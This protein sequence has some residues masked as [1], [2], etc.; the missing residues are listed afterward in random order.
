VQAS[1][2]R[3]VPGVGR[4]A[5]GLRRVA[6]PARRPPLPLVAAGALVA[7]LALVP[8]AYLV[9]RAAGVADG[10]LDLVFRART[11]QV[12]ANTLVLA[13]LVGAGAVALGLPI[14]LLTAR[15][16][17]PFRRAVTILAVVP[18]AVPSY[19]LAFAVIGMLG[20]NGT[21][22]GLLAPLGVERLPS[23]YGLPGATLVL[24]LA[25]YPLVVLGVR[26]GA[27]RFDAGLLEAARTLGDNERSAFRHV[28]L[29]ILLPAI[30]GGALLAIL[31]ALAD[32]GSVSL[33]QFDSLSRAIYVQYRATFDRS[34][35]A[36]L[37]LVLA[38]LALSVAVLEAWV[39]SRQPPA[40]ARSR[41]R[42][43]PPFLLGRWRWPAFAFCA[44]VIGLALVLPVGTLVAWLVRGLANDEPLRLVP[45]AA[46]NTLVASGAAAG[47]AILLAAP[48]A[49]L[50]VRSPGR[51]ASAVEGAAL[52]S[53]ALPGIVVALAVVFLA[54]GAIPFAYQTFGLLALAYAVRFLP[55]GL[56]PLRDGLRSVSPSLEQ[57]ARVLGRRPL[58]AFWSVTL[59]LLRPGLAAGLALVFLTTAK[60]LPMTLILAPT[61]FA[62][63]ATQVWGAVGDGFYARA[64]PSALLLVG[65]SL[66]SVALLL[67][68][69]G[70]S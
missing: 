20:P 8:L 62:T 1:L 55:Q 12:V 42:P 51:V 26:A 37:S 15:T 54:T 58:G 9:I 23:I 32:F 69:E 35:A 39:R 17:L 34:L 49:L 38:A 6:P 10:S 67:R 65:L 18:L 56:N 63:L 31:Y 68:T 14:G 46:W 11:A 29:P 40:V 61:G 45:G 50:L 66:A 7:L 33:L 4:V 24:T 44:A 41:Q 16:D 36:V 13:L 52:T 5:G 47:V 22:A 43:L 53:Y 64:A 70:R 27:R 21:L 28:A 2:P 57:S 60:E 3:Q 19:V 25:T 48:V 59:P 30:T